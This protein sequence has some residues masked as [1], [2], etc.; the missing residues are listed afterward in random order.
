MTSRILI[1]SSAAIL[2][3]LG[4]VHLAYTFLTHKFS[5]AE[6]PLELSMKQVAP[7]ISSETTMWKAWKGFNVSHSMGL[8]L[9]ALIYGY[10][11]V[12]R[13]EVLHRSYFLAGT[14]LLML[15]GYVVLARVFWF[16]APLIGVSAATL[17]YV[18]G[19]VYALVRL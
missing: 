13:W 12:Y 1:G 10:L 19:I 11:V 18:V 4:G 5:P 3:Y 6:R 14:G 9:F 16:T 7:R 17:L 15:L 2:L 8:L